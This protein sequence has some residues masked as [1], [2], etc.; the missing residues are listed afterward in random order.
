MPD[1]G[2]RKESLACGSRPNEV[3]TG[4]TGGST[5]KTDDLNHEHTNLAEDVPY[6]TRAAE[7]RH[8]SSVEG[9]IF[10]DHLEKQLLK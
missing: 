1:E 3:P 5:K 10:A 8:K 2:E 4:I 6:I 9:G 7:V